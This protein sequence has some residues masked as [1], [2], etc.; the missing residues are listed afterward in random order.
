MNITWLRIPTGRRQTSWLFT[1]VAE[2]FNW[3]YQETTP[4]K[5]SERDSNPRIKVRR[6]NHQATLPPNS[7]VTFVFLPAL[8]INIIYKF[9]FIKVSFAN[10]CMIFQGKPAGTVSQARRVPRGHRSVF[11]RCRGR[12]YVQLLHRRSSFVTSAILQTSAHFFPVTIL[13]FFSILA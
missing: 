7:I 9:I 2:E 13:A 3:V 4:A 8:Q 12:W 6:P 11:E 10:S 5:W 1:N